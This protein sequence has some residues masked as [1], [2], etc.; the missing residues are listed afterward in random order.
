VQTVV[1]SLLTTERLSNHS[2][3]YASFSPSLNRGDVHIW[4]VDLDIGERGLKELARLL[5]RD[6]IERG[7][8]F[9][10]DNDRQHFIA[11]RGTLRKILGAYIGKSPQDLCFTTGRYGK[12]HLSSEDHCLQFNLSHSR[13]VAAIAVA[14]DQEVGIDIE[15]VDS[16]FDVLK[17]APNVFSADDTEKIRSHSSAKGAS[18]FFTGWT[19]KEALLKAMGEGLSSSEEFPNA[20]LF[21]TD[22]E[23]KYRSSKDKGFRDWSLTSFWIGDDFKAALAVEGTLGPIKF[24]KFCS[25]HHESGI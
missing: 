7:D 9:V 4:R 8:R 12:P 14:V 20:G 1:H 24:L 21:I 17:V 6:E 15:F 22:A 11:A 5:S 25:E 10:F 23:I 19:R 3:K 13:G 18:A 16:Q 2:W